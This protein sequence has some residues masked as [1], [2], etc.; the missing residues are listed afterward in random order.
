MTLQVTAAF[1]AGPGDLTNPRING[2][3]CLG[4]AQCTTPP[5]LSVA[6]AA[7]ADQGFGFTARVCQ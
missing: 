4:L 3:A 6:Q 5:G 7:A 2:L 1:D